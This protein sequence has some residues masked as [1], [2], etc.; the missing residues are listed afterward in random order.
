MQA[1]LLQ[2]KEKLEL[3]SLK[4]SAKLYTEIY[5]DDPELHEWTETAVEKWPE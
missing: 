3:Q 2:L 4:Q 1:A 5:D